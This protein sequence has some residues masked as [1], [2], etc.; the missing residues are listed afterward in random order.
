[1]FPESVVDVV[2]AVRFARS[3]GLSA[4]QSTGHGALPLET[5]EDAM[6]LRTSRM[7]RVQIFP[8]IQVAR[9]EAGAQ[10]ED[11]TV[12]AGEYGLAALAGTSPN[13]GV[14]GYTLGGGMGWLAR[15][16]RLGSQERPSGRDRDPRRPTR[17]R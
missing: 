16:Y 6:L 7:R 11:V 8:T 14:T 13:V 9:A 10:W 15:R 2:R 3:Q 4:A 17:T 12:P 5:L 1:V